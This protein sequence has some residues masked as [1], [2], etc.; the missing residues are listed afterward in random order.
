MIGTDA[1]LP[2]N[3]DQLTTPGIRPGD[4]YVATS[5]LHGRGVFAARSFTPGSIIEIC[6]ILVLPAP[7]RAA[8]DTTL[9]HDRYYEWNDAAGLALGFGCL[10]NHSYDPNAHYR[11]HIERDL[12]VVKALKAIAKDEEITINYNGDP[13]DQTPVWHDTAAAPGRD[14]PDDD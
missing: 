10:Y 14:A 2:E 11:Q 7:Q 5:P 6:P 1:D 13:A 12:V 8:L 3:F 4:V 9:L